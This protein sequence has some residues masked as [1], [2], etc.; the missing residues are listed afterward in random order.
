MLE[1]PGLPDGLII[2]CLLEKFGLAIEKLVFLPLGADINTAVYR[3]LAVDGASYFVKLRRADFS[4]IAVTLPRYLSDQ[5]ISQIITPMVSYEIRLWADVAGYA[6]ILYPFVEGQDASD[7][8]LSE[9]QWYD[10]GMALKTI[11][12]TKAP[13][14]L[15]AQI[16]QET[17]ASLRREIVKQVLEDTKKRYVDDPVA[18]RLLSFM[19]EKRLIILDL[20]NRAEILALLLRDRPLENVICHSDAHAWNLLID[21]AGNVYI[22]D[23]DNPILAPKERDLMFIGAG[24]GFTGHS[25]E[26]EEKLFYRGYGPVQIDPF[27]LAYYRY[28]RIVQDIA[29]YCKQLLLSVEGS[30]DREQSY[31]YFISNFQPDG[32][33]ELAYRSDQTAIPYQKL[34]LESQVARAR[35][36]RDPRN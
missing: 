11:H 2:D 16:P 15:M 3:A 27:A 10:F 24:L 26:S 30:E 17:Y 29:E 25:I 21:A 36:D 28:E 34:I 18:H 5:G 32:T 1:K 20:V 6:L 12:S 33:I 14:T 31:Q 19:H 13:P 35:Y 9:R 7:V 22:V 8:V 23:W 4:E